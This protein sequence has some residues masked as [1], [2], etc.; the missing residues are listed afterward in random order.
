VI[1]IPELEAKAMI[2]T[3][4]HL[5]TNFSGSQIAIMYYKSKDEVILGFLENIKKS[6]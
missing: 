1:E 5:L 6:L 4:E 2:E 3:L